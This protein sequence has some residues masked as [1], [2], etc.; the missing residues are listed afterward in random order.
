MKKLYTLFVI[1]MLAATM[2]SAQSTHT[3]DF[4]PAGIGAA[5]NWVV[6]ENGDNP[7]LEFVA[8]PDASGINTSATVAKFTAKQTGNPW[9]LFFTSDDGE[10]T[11]DASNATVKMMVYKSSSYDV[12]FKVEG[13]SA[14]EIRLTYPENSA[15]TWVELTFDFSSEIG[16]T[17]NKLVI[18]PDFDTRSADT[19]IFIDNIQVPDGVVA[20]PLSEPSVAATTPTYDQADVKA[21]YS[22]AYAAPGNPNYNPGWGQATAM[23]I[24]EVDGNPTIKYEGLTYQGNTFDAIDASGMDYLHVDVWTPDGTLLRVS[25]INTS[26]G[27]EAAYNFGTLA[28]E[29]WISVDISLSHFTDANAAL[30]FAA[31]DQLKFDSQ[32]TG[33]EPFNLGTFYIDNIYFYK[34]T[35]TAIDAHQQSKLRV[36]P[37]PVEDMLHIEGIADTELIEL[38][39]VTGSLIK[40]VPVTGGTISMAELNKGVY[41]IKANKQTIKIIKK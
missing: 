36:F 22:D 6:A 30:S 29:T 39:S 1:S 40:R 14:K 32:V 35:A 28:S 23:S 15:N 25:P 8:N 5:W 41:F 33:G 27:Q 3:I 13:G 16:K 19:E 12:A 24:V 17:F 18:I 7:A 9:A 21:I 10:F 26:V 2:A 20:A 34:S 37:N 11:F 38:Y 31:I 4:E